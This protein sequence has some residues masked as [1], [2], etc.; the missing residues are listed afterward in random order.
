MRNLLLVTLLALLLQGCG[1]I[2]FLRYGLTQGGPGN[3]H[4]RDAAPDAPLVDRDGMELQLHD[5][6]GGRPL[7]L[8]FG[9]FT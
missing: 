6:L 1:T 9:S 2:G 4:R 3:L 8:I 5:F 7:V